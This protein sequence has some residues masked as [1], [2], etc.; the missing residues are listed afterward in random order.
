M[1][2][3]RA[4]GLSIYAQRP[5]ARPGGMLDIG[6]SSRPKALAGLQ[7]SVDVAAAD[8]PLSHR[9]CGPTTLTKPPSQAGKCNCRHRRR[10]ALIVAGGCRRQRHGGAREASIGHRQRRDRIPG[11][12]PADGAEACDPHPLGRSLPTSRRPVLAGCQECRFHSWQGGQPARR[13]SWHPRPPAPARRRRIGRQPAG[14]GG[15]VPAA[16]TL[17]RRPVGRSGGRVPGT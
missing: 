15:A 3:T 5:P 4:S 13:D 9:S 14:A 10:G 8:G 1:V 12:G 11:E 2:I 17:S 6:H 7:Q 16:G